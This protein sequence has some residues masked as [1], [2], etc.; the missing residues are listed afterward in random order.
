[1]PGS[2]TEQADVTDVELGLLLCKLASPFPGGVV[3]DGANTNDATFRATFPF[4]AT[5]WEGFANGHGN[6]AP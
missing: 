2:N 4:L 3:P 5:P 6:P 1:V